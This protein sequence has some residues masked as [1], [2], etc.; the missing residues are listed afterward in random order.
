MFTRPQKLT[1]WSRS[2]TGRRRYSPS[3]ATS[4]IVV[5]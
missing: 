4:R 1:A 5:E 3:S 2:F